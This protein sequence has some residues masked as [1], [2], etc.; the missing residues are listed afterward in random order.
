MKFMMVSK[1]GEGAHLLYRIGEEDNDVRIHIVDK[2]Y[3][4]TFSGMLE[5]ENL[6][7]IDKDTIVIFDFSGMGDIA[8]NLR[9]QGHYVFGASKFA[10]KLENDRAFGLKTMRDCGIEVPC[11]YEFKDFETSI[12]FINDNKEKRFV[13]KPSGE[14]LPSRLTYCGSD[15]EDLIFYMRYVQKY[16]D[17]DID[18]FI[19]QEFVG[20]PIVSSEFW[21]AGDKGFIWP[22]NHTVE[23]KKFMND[24]K[25]PSTGCAGNLI[26]LAT[27]LDLALDEGILCIEETCV[28]ERYT[29]CIDLNAIISNG[30][31]YGLEWTPRFGY[32]AM[33]TFLQ[34]I[35]SEWGEFFSDLT[36]GQMNEL[37]LFNGYAAGARISIPPYPLEPEKSSDVERVGPNV[38]VPIRGF[39]E[40]NYFNYYFFE[41]MKEGDDLVHS[42]GTGAIAVVSDYSSYI[43][44]C[45]DLPYRILD[46]VKVPDKQYRTDLKKVL[47]KMAKEVMNVLD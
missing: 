17:K 4:K 9:A 29:G 13:F 19:L 39:N 21:C 44:K 8:D 3:R 18:S 6:S 16:Y 35:D 37:P 7:W 23:V 22:G 11:T 38:G 42:P 47:P 25:G 32:D 12:K 46:G 10:D 33:P 5:Q 27:D 15:A 41:V 40:E 2:E 45:L 36:R 43:D 24:D 1:C 30:K 26:W 31:V 14:S 34:L 20:G 28:K